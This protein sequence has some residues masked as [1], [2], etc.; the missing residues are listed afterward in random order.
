M[1][2]GRQCSVAYVGVIMGQVVE[3]NDADFDMITSG[4]EWVLVDFWAPW[5]GPCKMI[6]P[7]LSEIATERDITI[8]KVNTDINTLTP[9]K[10][11]V[12]GIPNLL[13]FHNG[14]VVEQMTG[15]MPKP[16]MDDWLNRHMS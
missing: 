8:A 2:I 7:V 3:V 9:G 12:R 13:L 15:A 10:Y 4:N 11:G 16:A 5:C 6:A 1:L 14:K